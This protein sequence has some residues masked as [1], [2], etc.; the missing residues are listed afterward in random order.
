MLGL[1]S[2]ATE[3]DITHAYRRLARLTHPDATGR[4]DP[5]ALDRFSE[6]TRAYDHLVADAHA[7][8]AQARLPSRPNPQPDQTTDPDLNA[9]QEDRSAHTYRQVDPPV[10]IGGRGV[11]L[12]AAPGGWG[13]DP[14]LV[15]GPTTV[16]PPKTPHRR[17]R[18]GPDEC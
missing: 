1:P 17:R 9:D 6:I 10:H 12:S 11:V 7:A 8:T 3:H 14:P 15:A 5:T 4:N 16:S 18:G 13:N 2:T